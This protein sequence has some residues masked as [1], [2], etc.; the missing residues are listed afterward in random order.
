MVGSPVRRL[1]TITTNSGFTK[2]VAST[3]NSSL[4][5]VLDGLRVYKTSHGY[6]DP[7]REHWTEI[8]L[9]YEV[10]IKHLHWENTGE[11]LDT[12]KPKRKSSTT[13][14]TRCTVSI[15][16]DELLKLAK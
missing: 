16:I 8:Q 11:V 10:E 1:Q 5:R 13:R 6:V 2:Q 12:Q 3:G 9:R 14:H 4:A 7:K 15:S